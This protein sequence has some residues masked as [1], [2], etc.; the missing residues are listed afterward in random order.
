[1]GKAILAWLNRAKP[2]PVPTGPLPHVAGDIPLP[3]EPKP[4]P[5]ADVIAPS[6][7]IQ[8]VRPELTVRAKSEALH[9]MIQ[10]DHDG[11]I[12]HVRRWAR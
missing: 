1:M 6:I 12:K 8:D 10:G 5:R 9:R 7:R 11:A 2:L 3:E 4:F